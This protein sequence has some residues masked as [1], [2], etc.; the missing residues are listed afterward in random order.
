MKFHMALKTHWMSRNIYIWK[1][2]SGTV[3]DINYLTFVISG[4]PDFSSPISGLWYNELGSEMN[5]YQAAT[6][7]TITGTVTT[8][9][10]SAKIQGTHISA[11]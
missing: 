1:L 8:K 10:T 7:T 2:A 11:M 6:T 5:L 3:Y 4:D 9:Y